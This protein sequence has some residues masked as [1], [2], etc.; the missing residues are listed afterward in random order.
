VTRLAASLVVGP[1]PLS[2][3]EAHLEGGHGAHGREARAARRVG[4]AAARRG[5]LSVE[6]AHLG[7]GVAFVAGF[8]CGSP[9]RVFESDQKGPHARRTGAERHTGG[10]SLEEERRREEEETR[11]TRRVLCGALRPRPR[12]RRRSADA[13]A[14]PPMLFVPLSSSSSSPSTQHTTQPHASLFVSSS[15]KPKEPSTGGGRR[16]A[17]HHHPPNRAPPRELPQTPFSSQQR[18]ANRAWLRGRARGTAPHGISQYQ[19]ERHAPPLA[20][21][22]QG[23]AVDDRGSSGAARSPLPLAATRPPSG[24]AL[25]PPHAQEKQPRQQQRARQQQ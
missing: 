1:A 17:H 21:A 9:A 23:A 15:S 7:S 10:R 14:P 16:S 12:E 5:L 18:D 13:Q 3:N 25:L 8:G 6:G 22:R 20:G 24:A 4:R 19:G 2:A 11:G